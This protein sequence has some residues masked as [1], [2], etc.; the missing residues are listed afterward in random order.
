[1]YQVWE[2][3]KEISTLEWCFYKKF[4]II[5]FSACHH[6]LTCS[7][8][9]IFGGSSDGILYSLVLCRCVSSFKSINFLCVQSDN[10]TDLLETEHPNHPVL[11]WPHDL[12]Q[13]DQRLVPYKSTI[14]PPG[15]EPCFLFLTW[16]HFQLSAMAFSMKYTYVNTPMQNKGF[17][18]LAF[19]HFKSV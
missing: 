10:A 3:I 15:I 13:S 1:M 5:T 8:A 9:I 2:I 4:T 7:T 14:S 12:A 18:K 11:A 16:A 19:H 6:A 17:C